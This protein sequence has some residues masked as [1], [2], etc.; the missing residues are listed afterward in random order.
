MFEVFAIPDSDNVNGPGRSLE[1]ALGCDGTV[2]R[3]PGAW[4]QWAPRNV[5]QTSRTDLL[6]HIC[7]YSF[8]PNRT[9]LCFFLICFGWVLDVLRLNCPDS[10]FVLRDV[11]ILR[12]SRTLGVA[13][14]AISK[15]TSE[16]RDF[17]KTQ[18]TCH[19]SLTTWL[20]WDDLR[21]F[22][23]CCVFLVSNDIGN[24]WHLRICWKQDKSKTHQRKF[25]SSNF[26]LY[27]KLPVALAA[28]MFDSRDVLAGRNCAKC[29]VFP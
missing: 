19:G 16:R 10:P 29:C 18:R 2:A 1:R 25:R 7:H 21:K 8:F 28:S 20:I 3:L 26:R 9:C 12:L 5:K 15:W 24:C 11:G 27:W 6:Y 22:G 13:G 14:F 4:N 23:R 17:C